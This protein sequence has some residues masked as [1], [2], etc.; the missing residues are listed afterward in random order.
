MSIVSQVLSLPAS[1]VGLDLSDACRKLDGALHAAGAKTEPAPAELGYV[2]SRMGALAMAT[3]VLSSERIARAVLSQVRAAPFFQSIVLVVH[4]RPEL[5]APLLV[6][7]LH[8]VP[9]GRASAYV[10]VCGPSIARPAFRSGFLAPLERAL[11]AT[12]ALRFS[13]VPPWIAPLSGGCGAVIRARGNTAGQLFGVTLRYVE[14]YLEALANAPAAPHA[15]ENA[16]SARSVADVARANGK[17]ATMLARS[18][19]HATSARMM[20][21]LWNE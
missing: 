17:A 15:G 19:G 5:D 12:P 2:E 8:V 7:D 1:R 20:R 21:L 9:P 3:T 13:A 14:T 4:P 18:F 10:D 16:A 11:G 6:V